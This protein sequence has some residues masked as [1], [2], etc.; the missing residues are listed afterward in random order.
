MRSPRRVSRTW[1]PL[2]PIARTNCRHVVASRTHSSTARLMSAFQLLPPLV[3]MRLSAASALAH[4]ALHAW[5]LL[6]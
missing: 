6:S 5:R 1:K 3:S 4:C 2:A